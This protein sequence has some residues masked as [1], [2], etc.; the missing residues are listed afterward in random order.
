MEETKE[1]E[2]KEEKKKKPKK[3]FRD[4][5]KVQ[6]SFAVVGAVLF[7]ALVLLI[8]TVGGYV[9]YVSAQ[10]YRIPDNTDLSQD[11]TK[12]AGTP[13]GSS[14]TSG[15]ELSIM[16]YNIGF[17]A[18]DHDYSF[19]MDTGK[20][21]DGTVI[22][23]KY[24]KAINYDHARTNTVGAASAA[25][26]Q[27]TDFVFVQEIDKNSDRCYHI[28]Q[29]EEFIGKLIGY[30]SVYA[31]NF[32][33]AYLAYPFNDP[34]GATEAGVATFSKYALASSTRRSYP[35]DLSFPAKFF[36]L[37]RCFSVSR[38]PLSN[39]KELVLANSHMSAYDEGGV[40][41]KQQLAMLTE[42]MS[43]EYAKGN[44]VVVG[45]DFN[46]DLCSS[47]DNDLFY[48]DE[49][50]PDWV[51]ELKQSDMPEGF[52]I[53]SQFYGIDGKTPV[54]TCRAA[55][56]PYTRVTREDGTT[57]LSNY[58]VVIDGFIVSDNVKVLNN[59]NVD[60]DFEFSDHN[61]ARMEFSLNL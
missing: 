19:F 54:P 39:G 7:A 18:Y 17:G 22:T 16:T 9:I 20:M 30:D 14:I 15:M 34:I 3:K 52:K 45:G 2:K 23:G 49:M 46:H 37:D 4:L 48:S 56:M 41:R 10:Y 58:T 50:H 24:A 12:A 35:V 57:Y 13:D 55:E 51:A 61:P 44:Y 27:N 36:D 8:G 29:Y 26:A 25:A 28:N 6:K 53:V 38:L 11:I 5:N 31:S 60:L 40:I 32:H 59:Y 1:T 43:E 42:F 47:A 33:T 21:K